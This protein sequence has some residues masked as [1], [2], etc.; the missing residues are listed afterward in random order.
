MDTHQRR[1][2]EDAIAVGQAREASRIQSEYDELGPPTYNIRGSGH[3]DAGCSCDLQ[4][5]HD[6]WHHEHDDDANASGYCGHDDC[7]ADGINDDILS[8]LR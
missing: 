3:A 8:G 4:D 5:A 7:M 2:L 6:A 1:K